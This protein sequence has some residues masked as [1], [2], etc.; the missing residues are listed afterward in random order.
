MNPMV[1]T[2]QVAPGSTFQGRTVK[3]WRARQSTRVYM[4]FGKSYLPIVVEFTDGE[5]LYADLVH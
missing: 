2:Q 5:K 4:G 3:A 1:R